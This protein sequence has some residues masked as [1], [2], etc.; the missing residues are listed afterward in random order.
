M[1]RSNDVA[2]SANSNKLQ[3]L[4]EIPGPNFRSTP[5]SLWFDLASKMWRESAGRDLGAEYALFLLKTEPS[6]WPEH[7]YSG[8]VLCSLLLSSH[9]SQ[10][11]MS[12]CNKHEIRTESQTVMSEHTTDGSSDSMKRAGGR[13]R[14]ERFGVR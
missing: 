7:R 12:S 3:Q 11:A 5:L 2:I 9:T 14:R 4:F 1:H 10:E 13:P 8:C 6:T